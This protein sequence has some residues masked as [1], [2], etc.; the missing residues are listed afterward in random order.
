MELQVIE[1]LQS[2]AT[3]SS[4]KAEIFLENLR[5]EDITNCDI[6]IISPGSTQ[7]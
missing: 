1:L 3:P 6:L 5:S 7:T 2:I 4:V